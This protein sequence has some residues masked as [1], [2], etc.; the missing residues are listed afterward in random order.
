MSMSTPYAYAYGPPK[1]HH[2][3]PPLVMNVPIV[4]ME[5]GIS[6]CPDQLVIFFFPFGA[7]ADFVRVVWPGG[8]GFVRFVKLGLLFDLLGSVPVVW[9]GTSKMRI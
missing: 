3:Y 1:D 6:E 7:V 9:S 8:P 5:R 4:D 2:E